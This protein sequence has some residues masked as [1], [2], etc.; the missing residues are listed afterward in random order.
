MNQV[1]QEEEV[2]E[3]QKVDE[4]EEMLS[5]QPMNPDNEYDIVDE[6]FG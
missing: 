2:K 5:L 6:L 3:E 1:E 4:A